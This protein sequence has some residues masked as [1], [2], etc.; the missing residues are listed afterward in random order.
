M[1][2]FGIG[3]NYAAHIEELNNERPTEPVIFTMPDTALLIRNRPFYYPT[4]SDDIHHEVEIVLKI[5]KVGK[6]ID[7][8]FAHTYYNE[9]GIGIDFTA[10]DLQQKAKEKGLP[11][12]IAK[13]FNDAAPI[14]EFVPKDS[15]DLNNLNFSLTVDGETR[16]HGNTKLMLFS[17]DYIISYL[18]KFFLLKKGDLIYTGTPKG[19][20]PVTIGN[21]LEAFLE[22]KKMLHV[23]IK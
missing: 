19:V 21:R 5:S 3:R 4:F 11:W 15:L 17:F 23:D 7:E 9:I 2:I 10:R 8:K 18:S 22:D 6:N 1:K 13:G 14:S 12:A 20:G 16:Q